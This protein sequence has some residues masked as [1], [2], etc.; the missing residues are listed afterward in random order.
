MAGLYAIN[1]LR[2][3]TLEKSTTF[4]GVSTLHSSGGGE[5]PAGTALSLVLDTVDS[6]S[7]SPVDTDLFEVSIIEFLELELFG[8]WK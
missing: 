6:S 4:N 8:A 7:L 2:L 5:S 3:G 1:E